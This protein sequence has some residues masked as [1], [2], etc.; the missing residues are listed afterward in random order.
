[1]ARPC[2]ARGMVSE[3]PERSEKKPAQ[4][5]PAAP[6]GYSGRHH[7]PEHPE[8]AQGQLFPYVLEPR[9][10]AEKALMAVIQEAYIHGVSHPGG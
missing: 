8:A 3:A 4:W 2:A 7:R 6:V 9:R 5:L 1:M 10:T